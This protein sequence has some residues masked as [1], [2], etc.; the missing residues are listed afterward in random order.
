MGLLRT[1]ATAGMGTGGEGTLASSSDPYIASH[2]PPNHVGAT[3]TVR[4]NNRSR[5]RL[6]VR[7]W[8]KHE[9]AAHGQVGGFARNDIRSDFKSDVPECSLY[10]VQ[11][12]AAHHSVNDSTP[13]QVETTFS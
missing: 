9:S 2:Q 10:C 11:R 7:S 6:A 13:H 8:D 1:T 4:V 12:L 5:A 3:L